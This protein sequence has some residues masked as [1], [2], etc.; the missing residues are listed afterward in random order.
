MALSSHHSKA[1][2]PRKRDQENPWIARKCA[3]E[4]Q[5]IP[6]FSNALRRADQ[7]FPNFFLAVL[8]DF[9]VLAGKK[10]GE[11]AHQKFRTGHSA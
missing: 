1:A 7:A 9:N 6:M 8:S 4:A 5:K 2:A 10:I 11:C 3:N